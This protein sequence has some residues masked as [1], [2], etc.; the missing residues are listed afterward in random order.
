MEVAVDWTLGTINIWL[1]TEPQSATKQHDVKRTR[2]HPS[3]SRKNRRGPRPTGE[4]SLGDLP[5]LFLFD[6]FGLDDFFFLTVAVTDSRHDCVRYRL[7]NLSPAENFRK[8]LEVLALSL[9]DGFVAVDIDVAVI[10]HA[11]AGRNQPT[12]DH[13]FFQA[14]QVINATRNGSF[15]KHAR[16]LLE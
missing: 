7:R 2:N 13:V 3:Q 10:L 8:L 14:A 11:G 1:L 9:A 12:H 4:L 15:G 16:R 5:E 6:C